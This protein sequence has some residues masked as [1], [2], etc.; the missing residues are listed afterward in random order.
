[1]ADFMRFYH[2]EVVR[3]RGSGKEPVHV[4]YMRARFNRRIDAAA[5]YDKHNS[6]MRK[7]NAQGTWSSNWDPSTRLLYIVRRGHEIEETVAPFAPEDEPAIVREGTSTTTT[8]PTFSGSTATK[9][10]R[11]S[12]ED[13]S[14]SD[15][16]SSV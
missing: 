6:H 10:S 9:R 4:G 12:D 13:D 14:G 16:D 8:Y 3:D 1:M 2:L 15:S 11:E 5:Y 7:L